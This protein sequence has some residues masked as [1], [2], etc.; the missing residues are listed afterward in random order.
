MTVFEVE[1][2]ERYK[3]KECFVITLMLKQNLEEI[4]SRMKEY[5]K[6]A[7]EE[8]IG[9]AVKEQQKMMESMKTFLC[10]SKDDGKIMKI[11][12][13]A[14]NT[15]MTFT[16]DMT[17]FMLISVMMGNGHGWKWSNIF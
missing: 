17:D 8:E 14:G 10:Y 7:S 15:E 5:M 2:V 11:V 16:D 9:N 6:D 3:E 4:K 1:K 13:K 12:A